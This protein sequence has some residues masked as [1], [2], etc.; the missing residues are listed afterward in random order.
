MRFLAWLISIGFFFGFAGVVI[1]LLILQGYSQTL[2][3][4]DQLRVYNPPVLSRV[5]AGDGRLMAEF[6]AERRVFVPIEMIPQKVIDAFLSAEDKTFYN[7]PGI[8]FEGI[9]AAV[10]R[11]IEAMGSGRRPVGASTITQQV[12]KNMLLDGSL[13][14]ERKLREAMLALR[15]EKAFT[16][17]EIL[18]LY[19]NEIFLGQRAY[20][21]AAAAM[22]YFNKTLDELTLG[23]AAYLAVLPKAPNNYHPI[24]NKDAAYN[25]RAYVLDQML[26]NGKITPAEAALAKAELIVLRPRNENEIYRGGDYAVEEIRRDLVTRYGEKYALGGGLLVRSTIDPRLQDIATKTLRDGLMAY[27]RRHGWRGPMAK[28]TKGSDMQ[29]SIAKIPPAAGSDA[30]WRSAVVVGLTP[31]VA[32]LLMGDGTTG[33]LPMAELKWAKGGIA[34]PSDLLVVGDVLLVE[35]LTDKADDKNYGLRQIPKVQGGLVAIDPHTGRILAMAGGFSFDMSEFNRVTQAK[36]QPGSSFKPFV[37]LA[38]L[39]SGLTPSSLVLDAPIS[40]PQGPGLPDWRPENYANDYLGPTTL[41]VGIEKSRNIMTVRLATQIG[42]DKIAQV[43]EAFG[44][45]DKLQRNYSMVLGAGETTVLRMT[46]AYAELVNGG[47]KITPTLIDSVQDRTGR[48]VYRH[49]AR[50]CDNCRNVLWKNDLPAP[51]LPDTRPL[52]VDPASAYQ[53]VH[54]LE[55]VVQRGTG[56]KAKGLP[57]PVAGKTGTTNDAKDNWFV[58]FSPDLAVGMY[59]GFDT[60][61]SLGAK[62]TGGGN[63]APMFKAFMEQA[64]KDSP[65]IPFRV[66][67]G[68]RLVRV[69]PA[70]GQLAA[71]GE[72]TAIWEAFKPGTEPRAGEVEQA[73][74][75]YAEGDGESWQGNGISTPTNPQPV[76]Q[77]NDLG[78]I[79]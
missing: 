35:K 48:L 23:E 18:E 61:V 36:R 58:G 72:E 44:I 49:D 1:V 25:R 79:Y 7:H 11:N 17:D 16:K 57:W 73:I 53:V 33:D 41:R 27:D 3:D 74:D 68:V 22:A 21:V 45:V 64:L 19:L 34:R 32:Q 5:H 28:L 29:A 42:I 38:A 39:L 10:I 2:P 63:A 52:L 78:G 54:I 62:E 9:A 76:Q 24:Q 56:A 14:Y 26:S 12:A 4:V 51:T 70:N 31:A 55:G 15:I 37:Y 71:P 8:D 50:P 77:P 13:S 43:A 67:P 60:P 30:K 6:A 20:G 66:P 47:R 40:L 59:I 75:N 69:N 65:P 46:T